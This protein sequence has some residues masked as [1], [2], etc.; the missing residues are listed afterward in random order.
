[1]Y[2]SY[3]KLK[4]TGVLTIGTTTLMILCAC[5]TTLADEPVNQLKPNQEQA[6]YTG[7]TRLNTVNII[8]K[9]LQV[10]HRLKTG[11][12][13]TSGKLAVERTGI[14]RTETGVPEA[15]IQLKNLTDYPQNILVRTTWHDEQEAPVD[16]P[17]A[18]DRLLFAPNGGEIYRTQS[19]TAK[20]KSFY[21][22][23]QEVR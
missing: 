1:M 9:N 23:I 3:K 8:D 6:I 19:I 12:T 4:K 10:T 17:T 22:E 11:Y 15:W 5:A 14:K 16:G 18:W 2:I 7:S 21:V 13:H 20:A